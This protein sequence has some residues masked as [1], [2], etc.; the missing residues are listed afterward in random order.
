MRIRLTSKIYERWDYTVKP[1]W[2]DTTRTIPDVTAENSLGFIPCVECLNINNKGEMGKPEYHDLR[3]E[4]E[5]LAVLESGVRTNI[6]E[7]ASNILIT[8]LRE[9]QI[10]DNL[11]PNKDSV[12]WASGF[13]THSEHIKP[14]NSDQ[15]G[16]RL[17]RVI[18]GFDRGGDGENGDFISQVQIAPLPPNQIAYVEDLSRRLRKALDG[19]DEREVTYSATE[20]RS[21]FWENYQQALQEQGLM[22]QQTQQQLA[23]SLPGTP[24][25]YGYNTYN[26][27]QGF[28]SMD[29]FAQQYALMGSGLPAITPQQMADFDRAILMTPGQFWAQHVFDLGE[30]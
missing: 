5:D 10:F 19:R 28:A 15:K 13:R 23:P 18:G 20:V 25:N 17:K 3:E 22:E 1:D 9:E 2:D 21:Q 6:K 29:E 26:P 30:F 11:A 7:L 8:S 27:Q 14:I 16:R 4:I 24:D 12:A